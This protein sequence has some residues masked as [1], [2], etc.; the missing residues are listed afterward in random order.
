DALLAG[1]SVDVR[2]PVA[3]NLRAAG[4]DVA[5]DSSVGGELLA[6][7]GDV[8]LTRS[9]QVAQGA[10]LAG[11]LVTIDG[12]IVGKL[13]AAARRIVVNGEVT[14]DAR[15]IAE[16]IELGPTARIDGA[17]SHA[18]RELMRA[19]GAYIGGPI[20]RDEGH[21]RDHGFDRQ[22]QRQWQFSGP[23]WIG[24]L[25]GY[26]GLLAAAA[27]LV[28]LFPKFSADAPQMIR[29]A[30]WRALALGMAVLVGVPVLAV[31]LFITLL[32]IPLGIAVF[33]LYPLL[34][35]AGYLLGVLFLAQ[36][37]RAALS[38][39][40]AASLRTTLGFAALALL[41]LALIGR[42]PVVGALVGF[43]TTIAGIGAGVLE[44][45]R[46]RQLPPRS[47]G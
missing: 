34:L 14:G 15:L 45:R 44:W 19:D 33:A 9:A 43:I 35:L 46:R 11:G 16:Q 5:I 8:T 2:A 6:A 10:A 25:V 20:T 30:P 42:L 32:G 21:D 31:L 13:R 27:V 3:D 12:K 38:G 37:A 1:G 7:G 17:L 24:L 29:A 36:R 18:S 4:G 40:A 22:W 28:L 41:A 26:L 47:P 23:W 39:D